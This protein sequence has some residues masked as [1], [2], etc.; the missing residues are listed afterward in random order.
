MPDPAVT[1]NAGSFFMN[2]IIDEETFRNLKEKV[3]D[4]HYFR[5]DAEGNSVKNGDTS[6]P[7]RYKIPAGW[8][9]EHYGWKGRAL[10]RA[11]VH[12]KQALVLVNRGGATGQDIVN[13]MQ[14][15]Q[16]DVKATFGLDIRPEVNVI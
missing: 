14:A 4:V 16:H 8:L 1:G 2:P 6:Q 9:I 5:V 11:G 3:P 12:S 15:I 7:V 13:L 10:G